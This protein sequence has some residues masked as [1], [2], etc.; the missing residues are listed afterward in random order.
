MFSFP[1]LLP[2]DDVVSLV[3]LLTSKDPDGDITA[4]V[5][6]EGGNDESTSSTFQKK[7]T[8]DFILDPNL[9]SE[10]DLAIARKKSNYKN[11]LS[12]IDFKKAYE[13]LFSIL[14]MAN[15][16][17]FDTR[18]FTAEKNGERGNLKYCEWKGKHMSCSAIFTTFPS[19]Q[20]MCCSFNMKAAESIF[21][22][23]TYPQLV[24]ELQMKDKFIS[25]KK[26]LM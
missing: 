10:A 5:A 17:C 16:P 3:K 9:K 18:G 19:D 13:A 25:I 6:L 2:G 14:Y 24:Q 21:K 23:T 4:A 26:V 8:L 20:G 11:M 15:L 12:R 7:N 1:G 22:G